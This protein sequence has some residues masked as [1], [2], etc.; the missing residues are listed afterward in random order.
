M[1]SEDRKSAGLIHKRAE[2]DKAIKADLQGVIRIAT[3]LLCG[4]DT[5][6]AGS[7]KERNRKYKVAGVL[8]CLD[9]PSIPV[10]VRPQR[11]RAIPHS[12]RAIPHSS[13]ERT[14]I[15]L[16]FLLGQVRRYQ[17]CGQPESCDWSGRLRRGNSVVKEIVLIRELTS[18]AISA[19]R[20]F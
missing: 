1:S 8:L 6:Q 20:L 7:Q 12:S 4:M 11:M 19:S 10:G 17:G 5:H 2:V 3:D 14:L 18:R 13:M 16:Q 9:I 15:A